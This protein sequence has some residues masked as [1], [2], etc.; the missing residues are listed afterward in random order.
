MIFY[1]KRG[2]LKD[3]L[4]LIIFTGFFKE[5]R[6]FYRI[7]STKTAP[8]C[9]VNY[10][11]L[12]TINNYFNSEKNL[13][14]QYKN[15][16]IHIKSDEI[17]N[18]KTVIKPKE[19]PLIYEE[20]GVFSQ[21]KTVEIVGFWLLALIF[22]FFCWFSLNFFGVFLSFTGSEGHFLMEEVYYCLLIPL[23]LPASLLMVYLNWLALKFFR[24]S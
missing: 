2:Y 19:I 12:C 15:P 8:H 21:R 18:K 9:T 5:I 24:H 3:K 1:N 20:T 4:N 22:L 6:D 17:S 10:N 11:T 13:K 7:M 23:S 16:K 14:N